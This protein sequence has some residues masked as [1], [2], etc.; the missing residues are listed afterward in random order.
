MIL[1][2]DF[3]NT[4]VRY[5]ELFHQSALEAG[6][7]PEETA[8]SKTAVRN[9]MREAGIE[10][11]W[12]RLQGR[13]Y[14]PLIEEAEPFEGA[15]E[16]FTRLIDSGIEIHVISHKTRRPYSDEDHDLHAAAR[17]FL[18]T[19]GFMDTTGVG[20]TPSRVHFETTKEAKLERIRTVGCSHFVDDLPEFLEHDAFPENV[21]RFLFDPEG[22]H[23]HSTDLKCV[24]SWA[25][26]QRRL[27][28][29]AT[30]T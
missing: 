17:R 4:I 26:L 29:R 12:T 20:L 11:R 1:G 14:G 22:R 28:T 7:I 5:D 2:V 6:L 8:V 21:V 24:R 23:L 10:D 19:H 27:L 13:V 25:E 30:G 16:T 9:H 3:D 18:E 15:R